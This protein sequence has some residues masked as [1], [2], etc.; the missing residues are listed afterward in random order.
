MDT[1]WTNLREN[2]PRY[3]YIKFVSILTCGFEEEVESI[4]FDQKYSPK[5]EILLFGHKMNK[6]ERNQQRYLYIKFGSI[7]TC[8]FEGEVENINFYQKLQKYSL[9]IENLR[10]GHKVNKSKR[11]QLKVLVY[12]IWKHSDL[13]FRNR[14]LKCEKV[15][16]DD[17]G[18]SVI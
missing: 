1:K 13:W 15:D 9:K 18:K 8:V 14:S 16:A 17:N 10:F 6:S 2:Y 5:I 12:Q 3:M 11:E 4:I 7:L